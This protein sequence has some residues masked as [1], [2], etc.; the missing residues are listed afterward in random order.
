MEGWNTFI[1]TIIG[2]IIQPKINV[3]H[4]NELVQLFKKNFSILDTYRVIGK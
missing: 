3:E 2:Q 1:Y 4:I